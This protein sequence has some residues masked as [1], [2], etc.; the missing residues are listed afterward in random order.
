MSF[1]DFQEF[2][3]LVFGDV[4]QVGLV[5]LLVASLVISVVSMVY[6]A[7]TNFFFERR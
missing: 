7:V 2:G 4:V 6:R 1:A 3:W 5:V